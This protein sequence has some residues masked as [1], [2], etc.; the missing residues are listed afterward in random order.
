VPAATALRSAGAR[1]LYL[2]GRPGDREQELTSAGVETFVYA[3]CDLL[4]VLG[5]AH[6]RLAEVEGLTPSDLEVLS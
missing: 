1:S 3:G 4:E 2:A 5:N 6:A